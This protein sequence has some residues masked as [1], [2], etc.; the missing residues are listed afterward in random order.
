MFVDSEI[1]VDHGT[2]LWIFFCGFQLLKFKNEA[3]PIVHTQLVY[4][5]HRCGLTGLSCFVRG[6]QNYRQLQCRESVK[7]MVDGLKVGSRRGQT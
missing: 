2:L 6:T 5:V 3:K 7:Y 1:F 4:P